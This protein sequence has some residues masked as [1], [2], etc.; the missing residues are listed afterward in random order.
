MALLPT[1]QFSLQLKFPAENLC[2]IDS[3]CVKESW[4]THF[5]F[6]SFLVGFVAVD[7]DAATFFVMISNHGHNS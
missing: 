5:F 6:Y 7:N 2:G 1:F 4:L 3:T